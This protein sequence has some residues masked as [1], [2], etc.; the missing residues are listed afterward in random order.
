ML[1]VILVKDKCKVCGRDT[2]MIVNINLKA[3]PLCNSCA[4]RITMQHIKWLVDN[5]E[6]DKNV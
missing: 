4:N 5:Q 1:W 3:V 6:C 2:L